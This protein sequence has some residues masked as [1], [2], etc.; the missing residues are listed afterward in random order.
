V[1][2]GEKN[3]VVKTNPEISV[4]VA[5]YNE[6]ENV[7]AF[8]EQVSLVFDKLDLSWEIICVNDG[9]KDDTLVL[10]LS[11]NKQDP[12]VKVIDLTRNFGKEL[13]LSAAIDYASGDAIISIDGDL[14]HPPEAITDLIDKWRNGAEIV[15]AVRR[16]RQK[17]SALKR[18][19]SEAFY[20]LLGKISEVPNHRGIGDFCLLDRRVVNVLR[21]L[22]ERNRFMKGLFSWVGFKQ[23]FVVYDVKERNAGKTKWSYWRLWNFALDGIASFS[24]LPLRIWTYVGCILASLSITYATFIMLR[25]LILGIDVPGYAS[26]I[27]AILFLGGI[28]LISLGVIGEYLG[29]VYSEVKKRPLYITREV[30]GFNNIKTDQSDDKNVLSME[31]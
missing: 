26:L 19:S 15:F 20:F 2:F 5:M 30:Y 17:E 4:V 11:L 14:Q 22:T 29:R 10:L 13:A 25:T 1:S 7:L 24:T 6:A 16:T 12:R 21:K 27:V 9:S 18:F 28:Q 23:D 8:Y 3:T 31:C